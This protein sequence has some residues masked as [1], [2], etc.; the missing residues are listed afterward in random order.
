MAN[1]IE[2]KAS[3]KIVQDKHMEFSPK[4]TRAEIHNTFK[5]VIEEDTGKEIEIIEIQKVD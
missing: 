5:R 3:Y 4:L 1:L 2:Y